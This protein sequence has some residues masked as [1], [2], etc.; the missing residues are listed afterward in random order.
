MAVAVSQTLTISSDE[1]K[2]T[3][4]DEAE[5]LFNYGFK[6]G[7]MRE[8]NIQDVSWSEEFLQKSDHRQR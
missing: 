8:V 6:Y 3:G 4:G 2:A 1:A 7:I 5:E